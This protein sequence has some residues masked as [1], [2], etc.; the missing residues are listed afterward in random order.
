MTKPISYYASAPHGTEDAAI[1]AAIEDHYGSCLE[2]LTN[3]QK[4][5]WLIALMAKA[6]EPEGIEFSYCT[7]T[8]PNHYHLLGLSY[9]AK[10][11][12]CNAIINQLLYEGKE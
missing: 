3:A 10:L 4:S 7:D 2:R 12:L 8:I 5:T 9:G 6:V 11:S 1:L